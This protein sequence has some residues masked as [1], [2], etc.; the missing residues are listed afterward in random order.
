MKNICSR[1]VYHEVCIAYRYSNVKTDYMK[2]IRRE[3]N[4]EGNF[5]IFVEE[6]KKFVNRK[7]KIKSNNKLAD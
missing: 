7:F 5:V 4:K 3:S 6:C 1:C 2:K